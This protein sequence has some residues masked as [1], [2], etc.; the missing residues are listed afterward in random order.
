MSTRAMHLA[1][2]FQGVSNSARWRD[3]SH[4]DQISFDTFVRF[5]RRL[6]EAH[7]DAFFLAEGLRVREHGDR[8]LEIGVAG[9]PDSLPVLSA[10]AAVTTH[11]GLAATLNT[12]F[13]EPYELARQLATLDHLSGGRTAWNVVTTNDAW[14]GANFRRGGYL[15]YADRYSRAEEFLQLSTQLWRS[16]KDRQLADAGVFEH[17]GQHFPVQGRF[18]VPTSPQGGPVLFQA[19]ASPQGRDFAARHVDVVFSPFIER[20]A[21]AAF[22]DDMSSRLASVGRTRSSLVILPGADVVVGDTIAE[23]WEKEH[24]LRRQATS[25]ASALFLASQVWGVD[26]TDRDPFGPLPDFPPVLDGPMEFLTSFELGN[27]AALVARWREL[28]E[29]SQLNLHDTAIAAARKSTLVGTPRE[30]AR[31]M[32]DMVQAGECDGFMLTPDLLPHGLDD[33]L[34]RVVPELCQMGSFRE[35]Y[36]GTT[37]RG[38]LGLGGQPGRT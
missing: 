5:V 23:A 26:L 2:F 35:E 24:D 25:P 6:E 32:T 33:F 9:R 8:F 19:G 30:V 27:R 15:P 21:A 38:H 3:P 14:H 29:G 18:N 28:S 34:V 16:W 36:T 13:N 22:A 10:L 7:F 11:I 17:G 31:T 12:T 4:G 37:L 1:A 20:A